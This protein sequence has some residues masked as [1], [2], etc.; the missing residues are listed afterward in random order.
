ML[1]LNSSGPYL[2]LALPAQAWAEWL[3]GRS[4]VLENHNTSYETEQVSKIP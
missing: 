4:S 2:S 3:G 1:E